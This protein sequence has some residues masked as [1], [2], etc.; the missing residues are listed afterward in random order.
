M[1]PDPQALKHSPLFGEQQALG[2]RLVYFAGWQLPVQYRGILEEH[3]AVRSRAGVFDVSHLCRTELRGEKA[4]AL[5]QRVLTTDV[6][7]LTPGAGQY[8]LLCQEDG[9]ILDD[10]ILYR[11]EDYF[12]L[13]SNAAN[14]EKVRAWLVHWAGPASQ[15]QIED[16]TR[17][18]GMLAFQGPLAARDLDALTHHEA[19]Q[20]APFHIR[21]LRIG[22]HMA[23]ISRTGYT[24]EDGFELILTPEDTVRVWR[25]L[26]AHGAAPCG[27]GARDTLRLEAGY[28]LHGNDMDAA[29]N[30]LEV[31][32]GRFVHWDKG[33][34]IGREALV[35]A[36]ERGVARRLV[37]FEMVGR[38]IARRGYN[39]LA[40]SEVIGSVTSGTFAPTLDRAIGLALVRAQLAQP[41][42]GLA[43]EIRG[44]PVEARVVALPFYR[45]PKVN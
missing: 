21:A 20:L 32:L 35:K 3:R 28:L 16:T 8:T 23:L 13:V 45:R 38:G 30:P 33:E 1:E 11:L 14:A 36:K 40:G 10:A 29:T 37:G 44:E 12:L 18:T 25:H 17:Q 43:V 39:V 41:G 42:Q 7:R 6:T 31:G 2:A 5:L 26:L 9:G 34:F 4:A 22:R 19:A 15:P 24:G 27:L